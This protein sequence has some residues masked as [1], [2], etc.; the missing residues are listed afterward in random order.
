M[1]TISVI[2]IDVAEFKTKRQKQLL[3]MLNDKRVQKQCNEIL[4]D[5]INWFVPK[6]TGA[7]RNSARATNETISWGVGLPQP[8]AIYQYNGEIFGKN[9]PIVKGGR[10]VGWY[11]KPGV[12]KYPTGRM[13]APYRGTASEWMGYPFGYN[14]PGTG[15]HWDEKFNK[16][17]RWKAKANRDITRYLKKE[18]KDRGLKK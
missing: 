9:Y 8:Y 15:H 2:E 5:Y 14:V 13:M 6:N 10:I 17:I 18:C 16:S 12:K 3:A 4:K 7:L 1:S 11:S